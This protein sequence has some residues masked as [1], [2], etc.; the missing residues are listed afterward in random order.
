[1]QI[2]VKRGIRIRIKIQL[3]GGFEIE[4]C[5]AVDAHNEDVEA[6]KWSRGGSVAE[7]D[8]DPGF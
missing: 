6:Q 1:M 7:P 2:K 4:P 5:R 3:S 8:V